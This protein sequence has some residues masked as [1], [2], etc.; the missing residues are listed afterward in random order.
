MRINAAVPSGR[1][2]SSA[3]CAEPYRPMPSPA[4]PC[5]A[6]S[7]FF[8]NSGTRMLPPTPPPTLLSVNAPAALG[9]T[10]AGFAAHVTCAPAVY[11]TVALGAGLTTAQGYTRLRKV[12]TIPK[13]S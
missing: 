7:T 8:A 9:V 5:T 1:N 4:A 10:A 13:I 6:N 2:V 3:I 12:L 11:T